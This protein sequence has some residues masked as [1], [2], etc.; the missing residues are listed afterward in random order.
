MS[1]PSIGQQPASTGREGEAV[2]KMSGVLTLTH[3]DSNSSGATVLLT[4]Q[5]S[6]F[7]LT[8][9]FTNTICQKHYLVNVKICSHET[10]EGF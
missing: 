3:Q 4:I 8:P 1:R 7:T 9:P 10:T 6:P 2:A 5:S